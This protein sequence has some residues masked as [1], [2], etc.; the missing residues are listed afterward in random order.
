M[1]RK[2][3]GVY[4]KY[5]GKDLDDAVAAVKAGQLSLRKAA[6]RYCIPKS[7]IRDHVT[8]KTQ[9]GSSMGRPSVMPSS[10][11]DELVKKI[12]NAAERGFGLSR[13]Q[14]M[15]KAGHICKRLGISTPFN[16]GIPGKEWFKGLKARHPNISIRK[17]QKLS[18]ARAKC[19][20]KPDITEYFSTLSKI[21][22]NLDSDQIW[23]MDE[24][25]FH[26]EHTPQNVVS[27][28]GAKQ[29]PGRVSCNRENITVIACV[30]ASGH[31]M[32]PTFIVKGKTH[33]AL[34]SF[35]TEDGP[36]GA[37]WTWQEKAWTE[38]VLGA[39]WFEGED[40]K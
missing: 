16:S 15:V 32:P 2:A 8:G 6:A 38:D 26:L 18:T 9:P 21:M 39:K 33:K 4:G 17:P 34:W 25:G 27:R 1:P 36:P 37:T 23:N 30:S 5:N 19:M 10:V 22:G 7:T 11:E 29:V 40:Y 3:K 13:R 14:V 20:N 24:S 28:K 31:T 12:I 35:Q